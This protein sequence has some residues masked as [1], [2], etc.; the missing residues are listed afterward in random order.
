[1]TSYPKQSA[2]FRSDLTTREIWL[3]V[4]FESEGSMLHHKL[5]SPVI[6]ESAGSMLIHEQHIFLVG[7]AMQM[8]DI[9]TLTI[10]LLCHQAVKQIPH[11]VQTRLLKFINK[12]QH[13]QILIKPHRPESH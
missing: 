1:M 7:A 4:K 11:L 5:W 10:I 12:G 6:S 9:A 2:L 13:L 3:P 8:S